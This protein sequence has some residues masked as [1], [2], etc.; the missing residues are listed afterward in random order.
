MAKY[1]DIPDPPK[2]ALCAFFL[3][4]MEVYDKVKAENPGAR[5]T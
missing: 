5:I 2:K 1:L 4:R 3:Y